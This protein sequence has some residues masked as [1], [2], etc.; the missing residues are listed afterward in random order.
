LSIIAHGIDAVDIERFSKLIEK[1]GQSFLQRCFSSTEI[2]EAAD[3]KT[4][5]RLAGWFAVKE[6]VLKSIGTGQSNGATFTDIEVSHKET[7]APQISISGK[8]KEFADSLG[9]TVW[10]VSISHIEKIAIASV[11]GSSR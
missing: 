10:L 1:G 6:A 3:H 2:Q 9:I 11:I 7:G 5:E 4:N 8:T